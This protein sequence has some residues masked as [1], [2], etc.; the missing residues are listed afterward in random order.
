MKRAAILAVLLLGYTANEVAQTL[1]VFSIPYKDIGLQGTL[2]FT[3]PDGEAFHGNYTTTDS[4]MSG[5]QWGNIYAQL[6]T[7]SGY[8][9]AVTTTTISPT[10]LLGQLNAYGNRGTSIE[11]EYT[12]N[13]RTR[14]GVG[15]CVTNREAMFKMHFSVTR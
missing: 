11:C 6:G 10:S 2:D 8:S 7:T 4:S 5:Y 14:S 9:S 15:A 3:T 13:R 12:V 1:G